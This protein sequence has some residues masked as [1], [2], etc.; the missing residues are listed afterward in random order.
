MF[1]L[2]QFASEY[3]SANGGQK[4]FP[5]LASNLAKCMWGDVYYNK[6]TRKFS[7]IEGLSS[8]KRTF[9]EFILEPLYKLHSAIV[10]L[11]VQEL[12]AF[13]SRNHLLDE[14]RKKEYHTYRGRVQKSA[15]KADVRELLRTVNSRS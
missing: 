7:K 2:L 1:T 14:G 11:D 10:G 4:K 12:T 9:V 8:M 3:V 6:H 5:I 15:L 13:L